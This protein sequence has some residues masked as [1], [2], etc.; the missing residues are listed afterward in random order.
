MLQQ[1]CCFGKDVT[2]CPKGISFSL[3]SRNRVARE[4]VERMDALRTG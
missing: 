3:F 2:F 4:L 1:A